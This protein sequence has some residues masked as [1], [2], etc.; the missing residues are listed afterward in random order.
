MTVNEDLAKAYRHMKKAADMA[1]M[2]GIYAIDGECREAMAYI[3]FAGDALGC[4]NTP[5]KSVDDL[6]D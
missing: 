1:D 2:R 5:W 4:D 3:A 6:A